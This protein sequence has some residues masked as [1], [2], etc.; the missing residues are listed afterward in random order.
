MLKLILGMAMKNY[1]YDPTQKKNTATKAIT[2][3]LA[4]NGII[5]D[6]D[7]V[8]KYLGEAGELLTSKPK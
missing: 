1:R 3:D 4:E 2:D 6:E 8:R 7:T 5:L